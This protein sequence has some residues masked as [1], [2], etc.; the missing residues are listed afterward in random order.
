M[1]SPLKANTA[2]LNQDAASEATN[3]TNVNTSLDVKVE[4]KTPPK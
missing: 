4:N 3:F 2:P 1:A